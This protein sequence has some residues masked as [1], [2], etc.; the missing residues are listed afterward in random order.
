MTH[1][2]HEML[3]YNYSKVND[4]DAVTTI[5]NDLT[6]YGE[7]YFGGYTGLHGFGQFDFPYS[8][9]TDVDAAYH[10]ELQI[11]GGY[12][13]VTNAYPAALAIAMAKELGGGLS[14]ADILKTTDIIAK[15]PEYYNKYKDDVAIKFYGD[16]AS[17]LGKPDQTMK[18]MQIYNSPVYHISSRWWGWNV[19]GFFKNQFMIK[20]EP[21]ENPKGMLAF[22]GAY[23][24]PMGLDK[25]LYAWA[26]YDMSLE[27]GVDPDMEF[28]IKA[29]KDHTFQWASYAQ[30]LYHIYGTDPT[31]VA[32]YADDNY[33]ELSAGTVKSITSK[34]YGGAEFE[35]SKLGEDDDAAM[36]FNINFYYWIF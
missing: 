10:L 7:K 35:Y 12:G 5:D 8:K 31:N 4:L 21:A 13:R 30:F 27:S 3:T 11:G 26:E 33:M 2:V 20:P 25:Q 28:G 19:R 23:A 17:A 9:V 6:I 16:I 14:N 32:P 29:T 34:L 15:Y 1:S 24:K 22:S 36:G 18:I